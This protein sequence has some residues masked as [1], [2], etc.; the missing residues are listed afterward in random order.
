MRK[1]AFCICNK[2]SCRSITLLFFAAEI[3]S[4]LLSNVAVQPSLCL[5]LSETLMASFLN[6]Q[7]HMSRDARIQVFGVS[8]QVRHKLRCTATEDC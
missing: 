5:I 3:S 1:S 8:D 6:D 4:L 7:T 2:Q